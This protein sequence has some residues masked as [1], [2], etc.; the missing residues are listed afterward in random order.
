MITLTIPAYTTVGRP[1][2]MMVEKSGAAANSE[3][4]TSVCF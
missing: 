2:F 1:Y 4:M 3:A